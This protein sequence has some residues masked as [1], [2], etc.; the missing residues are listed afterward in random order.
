MAC[1]A[2]VLQLCVVLIFVA[3][4]FSSV[5]LQAPSTAGSLAPSHNLPLAEVTNRSPL[6]PFRP[7]VAPV[8]VT[9]SAFTDAHTVKLGG[10]T[11]TMGAQ[12][13]LPSSLITVDQP[14]AALA[15]GETLPTKSEQTFDHECCMEGQL[16]SNLFLD[17]PSTGT[18]FLCTSVAF[19]HCTCF[20]WVGVWSKFLTPTYI[21]VPPATGYIKH[22]AFATCRFSVTGSVGL[23]ALGCQVNHPSSRRSN[24]VTELVFLQEQQP[25]Q[26]VEPPHCPHHLLLRFVRAVL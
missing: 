11:G 18:Q 6:M 22:M 1:T 14:H 12:I 23:S 21:A 2:S 7:S 10:N 26:V 17:V 25:A 19:H 3:Q 8:W 4:H 13:P 15:A 16:T 20:V 5:Y 24:A 9:P